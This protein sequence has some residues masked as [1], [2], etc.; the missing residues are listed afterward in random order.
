MPKCDLK[1]FTI[2]CPNVMTNYPFIPKDRIGKEDIMCASR[3]LWKGS[4]GGVRGYDVMFS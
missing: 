1:G 4:G 2:I 3:E